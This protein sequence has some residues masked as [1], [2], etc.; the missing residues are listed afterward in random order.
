VDKRFYIGDAEAIGIRLREPC[1]HL[2]ETV[3]PLVLPNLIGKCGLR[4][5]ITKGAVVNKGSFVGVC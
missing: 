3:N 1:P 2:A 4:A 5:Q